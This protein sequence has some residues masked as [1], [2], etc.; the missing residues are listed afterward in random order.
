MAE[1]QITL[2]PGESQ[3]ITFKATP[4]EAKTY[5]I[6]VDGLTGTFRATEEA[7]QVVRAYYKGMAPIR[8]AGRNNK[9]TYDGR[10]ALD[11]NWFAVSTLW[12]LATTLMIPAGVTITQIEF[13]FLYTYGY[14]RFD[15]RWTVQRPGES[16][17]IIAQGYVVPTPNYWTHY[18]IPISS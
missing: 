11:P 3:T 15:Y 13:D 10:S 4:H 17:Q 6:S 12:M 8:P 16:E 2:E 1:Q 18:A 7:E 14:N 9:V 5:H